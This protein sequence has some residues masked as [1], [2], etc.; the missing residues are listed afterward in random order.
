MS[1]LI[2]KIIDSDLKNTKKL[3]GDKWYIAK[4]LGYKNGIFLKLKDCLAILL[5]RGHVYHFKEEGL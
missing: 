5:N 3:I 1:I 2:D 4:P